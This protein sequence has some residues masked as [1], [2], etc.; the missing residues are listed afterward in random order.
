MTESAED[1]RLGG[2]EG[3]G[4][5]KQRQLPTYLAPVAAAAIGGAF[6]LVNGW[7]AYVASSSKELAEARHEALVSQL[8]TI[9][10]RLDRIDD[11]LTH[12]EQIRMSGH[13]AAER[14]EVAGATSDG[15]DGPTTTPLH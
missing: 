15:G 9:E 3:P 11:R 1:G 12:L 7:F 4:E 5:R 14:R 6:V 13:P 10:R 2:G 8:E